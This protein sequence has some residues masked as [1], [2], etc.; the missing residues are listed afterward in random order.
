MRI[1]TVFV[2]PLRVIVLVPLVNVV[3]V[4]EVF[5]LPLT[6]HEADVSVIVPEVALVIVTSVN[7]SVALAA[8]KSPPALTV[9]LGI[10]VTLKA[11]VIVN[12]P[13]S[14]RALLTSMALRVL[15]EPDTEK[16]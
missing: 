10:F 12:V 7:V 2:A 1:A 5:Q 16:L 6:V 14:V 9:R 15:T 11:A 8:S 3:A 13:V 4:P